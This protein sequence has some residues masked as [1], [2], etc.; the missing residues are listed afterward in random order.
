M[1]L[2]PASEPEKQIA[3]CLGQIYSAF[4]EQTFGYELFIRIRLLEIFY[5]FSFLPLLKGKL[6]TRAPVIRLLL[7]DP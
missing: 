6:K 2:S 7:S 3:A 5:Q 1:V 4:R